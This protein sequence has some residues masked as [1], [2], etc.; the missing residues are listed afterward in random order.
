VLFL[1]LLLL[2][3][4]A[5][6]VSLVHA[7]FVA[8]VL[9][10]VPCLAVLVFPYAICHVATLMRG[11]WTARNGTLLGDRLGQ[12]EQNECRKQAEMLHAPIIALVSRQA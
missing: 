10:L 12:R 6:V 1:F 5:L 3:L 2:L 9:L 11:R 7:L 8:I 4:S